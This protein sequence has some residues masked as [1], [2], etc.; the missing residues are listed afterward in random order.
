MATEACRGAS[1]EDRL[2]EGDRVR[3]RRTGSRRSKD[4]ALRRRRRHENRARRP[5]LVV[6]TGDPGEERNHGGDLLVRQ[7]R[8]RHQPAVAFLGIEARGILQELTQVRLA[9]M[10]G[11]LGQVRREVR[12]LAE[13]RVAVDAVL[14]VPD[15]LALDHVG[16]DR[17]GV[18]QLAE[19]R[20]AM[21]GQPDEDRR[22]DRRADHEEEARVTSRHAHL[23]ACTATEGAGRTRSVIRRRCGRSC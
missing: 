4:E 6:D 15:V 2:A 20:M 7:L 10:L 22:E 21:D 17:V 16:R 13:Q 1:V 3:R 18:G 8:I 14:S 5:V 12:A 9:A 11:D 19:A 23:D